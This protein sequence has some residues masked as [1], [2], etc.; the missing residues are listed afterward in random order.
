MLKFETYLRYSWVADE[1]EKK[2]V[3][4]F[5]DSFETYTRYYWVAYEK[6]TNNLKKVLGVF[7]YFFFE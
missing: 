7:N 1:K 4:V 2:I 3:D 5:Y 6:R